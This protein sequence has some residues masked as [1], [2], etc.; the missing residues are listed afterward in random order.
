MGVRVEAYL[1]HDLPSV[2]DTAATLARL[3]S[4]EATVRAVRE[5]WLLVDPSGYAGA[6]EWQTEPIDPDLPSVRDYS[7]PG[8]LFLTVTP[9]AARVG[10]GARW[11]GF[12]TIE[13]LRRV[14]MAA[15]RAI[16]AALHAP[17]MALCADDQGYAFES[18]C[19]NG[20]FEDCL[21]SLRSE[22]G[23]PIEGVEAI[24]ADLEA[25]PSLSK[26]WILDAVTP[27]SSDKPGED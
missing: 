2:T 17:V 12:M 25:R 21:A 16:A 13:P 14:H 1:S 9:T 3:K 24:P 8:S 4:S 10:A 26:M 6:D 20:S 27:P 5:Y 7:G 11:S 19:G 15:L 22:L 23:A 18:F